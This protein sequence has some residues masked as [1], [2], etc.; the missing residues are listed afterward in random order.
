MKL[1]LLLSLKVLKVFGCAAK[2]IYQ[3]DIL[4]KISQNV[5]TSK[6]ELKIVLL[7]LYFTDN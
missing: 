4:G 7:M 5:P 3:T 1:I 2:V 6:H